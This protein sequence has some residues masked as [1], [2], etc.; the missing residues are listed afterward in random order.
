[1][2]KVYFMNNGNFDVRAMLTFG[3]S[4]KESSDAIG[5][6]GT[7]FKY[8]IAIILRLGGLVKIK[9]L[10]GEYN[11]TS[12]R[13]KI[14][15]EEFDLVYVNDKEA[16]FTTRLGINWEPWMAFREL[17]CNAKDE[18]G[19]ISITE[20]Q[21]FD[22]IIEVDCNEILTAF[23]NQ[24][25][26]FIS[27]PVIY[28][29]GSVDYHKSNGSKFL[30]YKG[31]AVLPYDNPS[32]YS[33]NITSF[34]GLTEDRT[35]KSS[36]EVCYRLQRSW[37]TVTDFSIIKNLVRAVKSF[38]STVGFDSNWETSQEF[39]SCC[40]ELQKTNMGISESAR[41]LINK[42]NEQ[43]GEW[44]EFYLTKVQL[45]MLEKSKKF[46][47]D[48]GVD[49]TLF[50]IKTVSGLGQGVLGRALDGVIYLSELPFQ[51]GT[52]QVASTLLEEWV[53]NKTG[54]NDF[55]RTMQTWLFDKILSI[56][57]ETRGE[58]L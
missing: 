18:S 17:Y 36:Y 15:N 55:D 32:A 42:L 52:K 40:R 22:T 6:F 37:Q 53:H 28:S 51:M 49:V 12:Q 20:D 47:T 21:S 56:G 14:R 25:N 48:I 50:P 29:D 3:V 26:Y 2:S 41:T 19:V 27:T 39:V 10:D 44:P 33:Y 31:V 13:T 9:T 54:A 38:E 43:N 46:L 1:M 34:I 8:A 7:G 45:S 57:E 58:P 5:Y 30:Y 11:F 23:F 4:A 35:V 16:G 24:D